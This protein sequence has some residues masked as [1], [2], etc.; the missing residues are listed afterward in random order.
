VLH[1]SAQG[2]LQIYQYFSDINALENLKYINL[3]YYNC[4]FRHNIYYGSD[5]LHLA[6]TREK[7]EYNGTVYQ[8]FVDLK[9]AYDSVK[10]EV[11]YSIL[12][13]FGTPKKLVRLIKM[14]LNE[15]YS[16][17]HIGKL[18]SNKFH[19]QNGLKQGDALSPLLF[20]F[21]LNH[22]IRKVQENEV[23][24]E[25]NGT[26]QLL[27]FIDVNLLGSS[28]NTIKEN[29][30]TLLEASR[31]IGL[32]TNAEKTKYMII[33]HHPNS[34][35]NQNIKTAN[36]SFESVAKFTYLGTMN[37]CCY[38]VQNILSS[39]LISKTLKIKI[40]KTVILPVVL[41]G[42]KTWSLT[43]REEHRLRVSENRVLRRI[44]GPRREEDGWIME[45]TAY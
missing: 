27:V 5:F 19:I 6:D 1:I 40:Y 22:A 39:H 7:W 36:E 28:M 34:G 10:R 12:L 11:L 30:Q 37:A 32:E 16:K 15:T 31:D 29:T 45:K 33:S 17:V 20:S 8:L 23:S 3:G 24:L 35:Q 42:C 41:Y 4:G 38:S 26:H 13:E 21:A 2:S 44:Y 14:C 43:L 9:K 25:L 18:L